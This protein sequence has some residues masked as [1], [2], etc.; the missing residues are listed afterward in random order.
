MTL[1]ETLKTYI[2]DHLYTYEYYKQLAE[3]APDEF[4]RDMLNDM[5]NDEMRHA[6]EFQVIYQ[7]ITGELY[8]PTV[9]TALQ[10][11]TYRDALGDRVMS[12]SNR[13]RR[14]MRNYNNRGIGDALLLGTLFGAGVDSNLHS[15]ALLYLLSR[16]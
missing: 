8:T 9:T 5:A 14:Y 4:S 6:E 3:N 13:Y 1:P 10:R 16:L 11:R 2:D 12:E 15:L 7:G